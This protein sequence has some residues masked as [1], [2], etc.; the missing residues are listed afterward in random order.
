[1]RRSELRIIVTLRG[2]EKIQLVSPPEERRVGIALYERLMPTIDK[3][4]RE[5]EKKLS[6]EV[7]I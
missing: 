3:F 7:I 5:V 1:M 6:R 2:V 4:A